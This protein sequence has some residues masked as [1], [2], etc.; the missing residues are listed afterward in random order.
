MNEI[1]H[2][3]ID[4][5]FRGLDHF[6]FAKNLLVPLWYLVKS[7]Y[8]RILQFLNPDPLKFAKKSVGPKVIKCRSFHPV[9]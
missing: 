9:N 4:D 5:H 7:V 8:P 3:F 2:L 6:K 1:Y